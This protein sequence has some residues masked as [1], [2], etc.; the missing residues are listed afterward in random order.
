MRTKLDGLLV[1]GA[2]P[3][4]IVE[5]LS[6]EVNVPMVLVDNVFQE[7]PLDSVMADDIGGAYQAV[8]HL[9]E[10]GHKRITVI[11]GRHPEDHL[12]APSYKERY[13]GY[14]EACQDAN[15]P[16]APIAL[17]PDE[18]NIMIES[19][20]AI[21]H[22]W[23]KPLLDVPEPP[24][25]FFCTADHY[26]NAILIALNNLG[27]LV[28]AGI[29]VASFDDINIASMLIP[30]LT[31]VHVNTYAIGYIA[32]ERLLA[33]IHGDQGPR[34]KITVGTHLVVRNSAGFLTQ[35]T[36]E[37]DARAQGLAIQK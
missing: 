14:L 6:R 32:T 20:R 16:T 12:L 28:P 11:A 35:N 10:L 29:S 21:L 2:Y 13:L 26:A 22:H 19:G 34:Q 8:R 24:T 25:A 7:L 31:T 36:S 18:I 9:I 33:R 3:R 1:A 4:A 27:I 17:I 30:S 15:L 37:P 23:L 5:R